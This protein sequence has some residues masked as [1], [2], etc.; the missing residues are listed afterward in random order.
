MAYLRSG[1]SLIIAGVS[2]MHF[3]HQFWYWIIGIAC[4]PTG[5]V[6]GFFGVW[7][8]ITISKSITIVRRELP[9]ADQREAEQMK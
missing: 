9:L 6:T 1:I 2:I 5:I 3:S 8:Y 4:I 7:R